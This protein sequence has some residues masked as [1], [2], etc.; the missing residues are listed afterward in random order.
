MRSPSNWQ[1][2]K[3]LS[4][5]IEFATVHSLGIP[6]H[7]ASLDQHGHSSNGPSLVI[8]KRRSCDLNVGHNSKVSKPGL[9]AKYTFRVWNHLIFFIPM[10]LCKYIQK[11]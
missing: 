11:K 1:P 10:I 5:R 2:A 9:T 7:E 3:P 8:L 6:V 4:L